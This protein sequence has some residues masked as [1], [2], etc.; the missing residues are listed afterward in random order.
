MF[1][2]S[3]GDEEEDE[4]VFTMGTVGYTVVYMCKNLRK[5]WIGKLLGFIG[6]CWNEIAM[7]VHCAVHP[8]L[9]F[10]PIIRTSYACPGL[11]I[12]RF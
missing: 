4:S 9:L 8:S 12:L 6:C 10:L 1:K 5:S 11:P 2:A 3:C 7:V